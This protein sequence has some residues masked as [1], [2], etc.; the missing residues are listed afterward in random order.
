MFTA[1]DAGVTQRR[2]KLRFDAPK[3]GDI[4]SSLSGNRHG[5]SE[6][7]FFD[8]FKFFVGKSG[9]AAWLMGLTPLDPKR[10]LVDSLI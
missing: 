4:L 10:H 3:R 9:L 6:S 5:E 2:K 7:H 1:E 8:S